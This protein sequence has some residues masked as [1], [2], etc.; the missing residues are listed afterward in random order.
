[1]A[2]DEQPAFVRS[3][4][5]LRDAHQWSIA[6]M[7]R[8]AGLPKRSME[9]YFKGHKPGLDALVSM[10]QGFGVTV[11]FLVGRTPALGTSMETM[12]YEASYPTILSLVRRVGHYVSSGRLIFK[13]ETIFS[14][15]Y[16]QYARKEAQE[17]VE[18][19]ASIL[20]HDAA[21]ELPPPTADD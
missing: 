5:Q 8:R 13:D 20:K 6:E 3:L 2:R 14:E 15:P 19:F 12:V 16:D 21:A 9:N 11:D 17:V 7:A 10:S 18:R 1:M 4:A